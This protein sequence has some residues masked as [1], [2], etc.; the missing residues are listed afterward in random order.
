MFH[1]LLFIAVTC[2]SFSAGVYGLYFFL[3]FRTSKKNEYLKLI[4]KALEKELSS[5]QLPMVSILIPA[6]N[7]EEVISRKMRNIAALDYPLEKTEV[8]LIDDGSTDN[9]VKIAQRMFRELD[10]PG[11]IIRNGK[12]IGVNAS[13]NRGVEESKGDWIL[14]TDADVTFDHDALMKGV[15]ILSYLENAG[16]ISAKIVPV[17]TDHTAAVLIENTYKPFYDSMLIAESA[18]YSTFPGYSCFMLLRKTAFSPLPPMH[19]SSDGNIS[20]AI[21]RKGMQF[22]YVPDILFYEPIPITVTEQRRQ[23][24]RRACRLLQST[25]A[26]RD[27][28]FQDKY[29]SFGKIIFPLRF[30][31]MVLC[32]IAFVIGFATMILGTIYLSIALPLFLI[33]IFLFCAFLGMKLKLPGLNFF[34]SFVAHQYYLIMGLFLSQ[35]K[36]AAWRPPERSEMTNARFETIS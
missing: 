7:E 3:V 5:Q 21:I 28:L 17:S 4:K 23:K 24:I 34:S 33:F 9:T 8:L 12:R 15:N 2:F 36:L 35:K 32:P 11:K 19:G 10:L 13:Y 20:L 16:G 18:I 30:A 31:M 25:L 29:K 22:L 27:M 6:Y 1:I 14:T 26:N